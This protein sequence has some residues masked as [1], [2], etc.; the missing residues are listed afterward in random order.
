MNKKLMISLLIV[1]MMLLSVPIALAAGDQ[2]VNPD[3]AKLQQQIHDLQ[4]QLV[5]KYVDNGQLTVDQSKNIQE[6]MDQ[7]FKNAQDNGFKPGSGCY[8]AGIGGVNGGGCGGRGG[9]GAGQGSN[10]VPQSFSNF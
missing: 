8:G 6:R 4:K 10:A 5:Q 1:G 2:S 9:I 7:Q 3:I